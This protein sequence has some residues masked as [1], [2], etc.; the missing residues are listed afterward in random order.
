MQVQNRFRKET[1]HGTD[2]Y[3]LSEEFPRK[4]KL[5][6]YRY[7]L[8]DVSKLFDLVHRRKRVRQDDDR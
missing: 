2:W 6:I 1:A 3:Q 7:N 5:K 4:Y 8:G